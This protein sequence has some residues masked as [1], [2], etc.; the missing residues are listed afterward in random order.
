MGLCERIEVDEQDRGRGL[1]RE[2]EGEEE[3]TAVGRDL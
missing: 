1:C 2:G 3:E